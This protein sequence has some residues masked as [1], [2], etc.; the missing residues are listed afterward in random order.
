MIKKMLLS[1]VFNK[2]SVSDICTDMIIAWYQSK[3]KGPAAD[4]RGAVGV[5]PLIVFGIQPYDSLFG[6]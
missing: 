3:Q 4:C 5:L 6:L 2:Y 1:V